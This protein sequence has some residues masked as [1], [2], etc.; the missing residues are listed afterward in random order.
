MAENDWFNEDHL[1]KSE[2]YADAMEK[3]ILPYLKENMV[4]VNGQLMNK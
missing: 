4:A 1:A 3:A 2:A